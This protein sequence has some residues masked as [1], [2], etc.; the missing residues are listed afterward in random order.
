MKSYAF[1]AFAAFCVLATVVTA[2]TSS[3][4]LEEVRYVSD[5]VY[6]EFTDLDAFEF[7]NTMTDCVGCDA[8]TCKQQCDDVED[9]VGFQRFSNGTHPLTCYYRSKA[10][11]SNAALLIKDH[12]CAID[13]QLC[14]L[15]IN[16]ERGV[17]FIGVL[18]SEQIKVFSI[19]NATDDNQIAYM[20]FA[21]WD[22]LE[23]HNTL[24]DCVGC[25]VIMCKEICSGD[26]ECIGFQRFTNGTS[27]LTCYFRSNSAYN[28]TGLIENVHKCEIEGQ[29]CWF[30]VNVAKGSS[31][32]DYLKSALDQKG[33]PINQL[34]GPALGAAESEGSNSSSNKIIIGVVAACVVAAAVFAVYKI[35]SNSSDRSFDGVDEQARWQNVK[36]EYGA[37]HEKST[38]KIIV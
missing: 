27:P 11:E 18:E 10:E 17:D 16:T 38:G 5:E 14:T 13:G 36:A 37:L 33:I 12:D 6:A 22:A 24:E 9:C 21:G 31:I 7:H 32:G 1:A 3:T 29:Q 2:Q 4:S 23:Y 20:V 15:Y 25:S 30:F 26:P 35:R 34:V 8:T 19:N 28:K